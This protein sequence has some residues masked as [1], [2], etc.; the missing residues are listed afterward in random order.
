MTTGRRRL[1]FWIL[2]AAVPG[3][4][5]GGLEAG[6]RLAGVGI[7]TD[8]VVPVGA[9]EEER[10]VSNPYFTRRF[11]PPNTARLAT[12]FSLPRRKG[13]AECRVF[14]FGSSAAQGDP[15]PGFGLAR[16]LEVLLRDQYPGADVHVINT[17]A[18]AINSHVVYAMARAATD[19][20]P[21]LF[22]L[23]TGNNEVIGPFGAGTV[24]TAGAPSLPLVR[25]EVALQGTRVGQALRTLAGGA[26]D[27][28]G[29]PPAWNGLEMFL[30]RPMGAD[31]PRLARSYQ[32][33]ARNLADTCR[34]ARH[35]GIP[36]VL[37][38]V[39]VNLRDCAP[40]GGG[41][42][43]AAYDRARAAWDAGA[44]EE[45]RRG[46]LEARDLDGLRFR[47]DGRI[48]DAIRR[49]AAAEQVRLYDGEAAL[50]AEAPHGIPGAETFLDHVHLT[51]TGNYRL[52]RGLVDVL[53]EELPARVTASASGRPPLTEREC[54]ARLAFTDLDRH[55][56][57]ETMRSRLL[58]PPF[59]RQ[60]NHAEQLSR[61]AREIEAL[62]SRGEAAAVEEALAVYGAALSRDG[63]PWEIHERYA[64][65][66]QRLGRTADAE[67]EWR[68]LAAAFPRYPSFR[69]QLARLLRDAGRHAEAAAALGVV[70]EDQPDS[71]L[72]L[73]E[74]ARVAL[75]GGGKDAAV[76]Y[77][78]RAAQV[79]PADPN[80]H[81]ILAAALCRPT[82]CPPE[83]RA[84]AVAHLTRARALAPDSDAIRQALERLSR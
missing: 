53:R 4:F 69:L 50:A 33:F 44:Y 40:F 68:A 55:R 45:A 46:Y 17:A 14:L 64:A 78:R 71:P 65:I 75:A 5:F 18:T 35:A 57:A 41:P 1:L 61:F 29:A 27:L 20:D 11:F 26:R 43:A 30:D 36:V 48:N 59:T 72:V 74:A 54:M 23:Y 56:I 51:F 6:L 19:L 32:H 2:L 10:L 25:A 76:G 7:R 38:T 3:V 58:R 22:I 9:G 62:R 84:E 77:A 70:L 37:S 49:M 67:R 83:D 66:L 21:D 73:A 31:D 8:F 24:L 52:A 47:A 80:A 12:P 63:A 39:G 28:G 13:G 42:A 79:D 34:V 81:Y 82:D 15:E 60:G 16:M